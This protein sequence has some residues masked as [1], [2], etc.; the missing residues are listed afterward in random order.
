MAWFVHTCLV[1]VFV[2]DGLIIL[3]VSSADATEVVLNGLAIT[4]ILEIDDLM[5]DSLLS[6]KER[7]TYQAIAKTRTSTVPRSVLQDPT[8]LDL[9]A[10]HAIGC[11][12]CGLLCK[13]AFDV[14][15]GQYSAG[16]YLRNLGD[17]EDTIA[18][19]LS[20]L[21][22]G[23]WYLRCACHLAPW[24]R[25]TAQWLLATT[26]VA[27]SSSESLDFLVNVVAS[28]AKSWHICMADRY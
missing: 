15:I 22:R 9:Y 11:Y 8:R 13:Y 10:S 18:F 27:V 17:P 23:F 16:T 6:A 2:Y 25:T 26:V 3:M 14:W 24:C 20:T 1:P 12:R 5:Y 19:A 7:E 21:G 4:F 28:D